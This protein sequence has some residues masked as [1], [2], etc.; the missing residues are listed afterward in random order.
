MSIRHRVALAASVSTLFMVLVAAVV[1]IG[2]FRREGA[3]AIDQS[4]E[5]QWAAVADTALTIAA[6]DRPRLE[7]LLQVPLESVSAIR[8]L[9]GEQVVFSLGTERIGSFTS[10]QG[11]V[12]VNVGGERWRVLTRPSEA[13]PVLEAGD[14][15]VVQVASP[16]GPLDDSIRLLRRSWLRVGW[17]IAVLA[18]IIGWVVA[19]PV[20]QPLI[21]L[22]QRME[23]VGATRSL[24]DRVGVVSGDPDIAEL[25]S[26]FDS[27]LERLEWADRFKEEA[28]TSART[29]G[30]AA[31]HEL[32][33][34]LTSL[35][36]NLDVLAAHA[37]MTPEMRSEIVRQM[38]AEHSRMQ[39]LLE[40]LRMLA[41]GDI[42]GSEVFAEVD[43]ADL[44]ETA[45][46]R[47]RRRHP[48]AEVSVDSSQLGPIRGWHEGL[49]VAI[50]NLLENVAV[51][52]RSADGVIRV[53]VVG[54][55]VGDSV[56][57]TVADAGPG[58]PVDLGA[59]AFERFRTA[60][61]GAGTGLGL[62]LVRQQALLH[63]G[64]VSVAPSSSGGAAFTLTLRGGSEY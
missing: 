18:G 13:P 4:L 36:A 5:T 6:L 24:S 43:L 8:V 11:L 45:V 9:S 60:G 53:E 26:A 54:E 47:F 48:E 19:R 7:E 59:A 25:A 44:V 37:E 58:V 50:D 3:R 33:T 32:R 14:Q 56:R 2:F 29:F 16:L 12:T 34:P 61:P 17:V 31:A 35:R 27:M 1:S 46:T 23:E 55:R 41:R 28:L 62:A 38:S 49:T 52:G 64:G 57:V 15:F 30:A 22:R 39:S 40:A 20:I 63:D 21:T 10:R 42:A 51:H